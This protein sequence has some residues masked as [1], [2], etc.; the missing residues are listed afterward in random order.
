[1]ASSADIKKKVDRSLLITGIVFL[2]LAGLALLS[3]EVGACIG[4]FGIV[5]IVVLTSVIGASCLVMV[6]LKYAVLYKLAEKA[7]G[8][9]L[10]GLIFFIVFVLMMIAA[11]VIGNYVTRDW[12]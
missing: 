3:C 11:Y 7:H 5:A 8:E 2:V 10:N 4:G 12:L 1:M 9:L 6:A